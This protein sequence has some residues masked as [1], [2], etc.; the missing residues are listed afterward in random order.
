M[1][2]RRWNVTA[3]ACLGLG[4]LLVVGGCGGGGGS[5]GGGTA[6]VATGASNFADA[7]GKITG[8]SPVGGGGLSSGE[9]YVYVPLA[10]HSQRAHRQTA[11]TWQETDSETG[12][13]W[14]FEEYADGSG[15]G[16]GSFGSTMSWTAYTVDAAGNETYS[17]SFSSPDDETFTI[18]SIV[19]AIGGYK[20][21]YSGSFTDSD[22]G[23]VYTYWGEDT[24]DA[25]GNGTEAYSGSY[26]DPDTGI[27]YTF[28]GED[29]WDTAENW[30]ASEQFTGSDESSHSYS[31]VGSQGGEVIESTETG[32][33]VEDGITYTYTVGSSWDASGNGTETEQY[34]GSDGSSYSFAETVT[35]DGQQVQGVEQYSEVGGYWD[36]TTYAF[37]A[38]DSSSFSFQDSDGIQAQLTLAAD[39]T[40][41]GTITDAATGEHATLSVSGDILTVRYADGTTETY[42]L[43]GWV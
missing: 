6:T 12:E 33:F 34:T 32:Q 41:S 23:V 16:T 2:S 15:Y 36:R 28:L 18:T 19:Y 17:Y 4:C 14:D 42:P 37:D 29:T 22:T 26:T 38:D 31:E 13:V 8:G 11:D 30:T 43:D 39:G 40:G 35:G 24:Y 3:L 27:A 21:T 10:T 9:A 5:S 1:R 25:A 20:D 7:L